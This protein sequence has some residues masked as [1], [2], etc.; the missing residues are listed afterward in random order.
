MGVLII[1]LGIYKL[2]RTWKEPKKSSFLLLNFKAIIVGL[3]L[4]L[5]G[6]MMILDKV[7]W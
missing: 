1:G 7:N 2:Y 5:L 3:L 4:V 6:I